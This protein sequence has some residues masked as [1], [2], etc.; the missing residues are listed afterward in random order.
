MSGI[1]RR[2]QSLTPGLTTTCALDD[3]RHAVLVKG[4][5]HSAAHGGRAWI[6]DSSKARGAFSQEI[7][8]FIVN[9]VFPAFQKKGAKYF[10]TVTAES[11]ITK[12]T[13]TRYSQQA[14]PCGLQLVEGQSQNGAI[15]WLMK[16]AA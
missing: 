2:G 9:E 12:M 11:A 10:M 14:G 13:V 16:K 3:F 1:Q 4:L 6:V 7:Q 5:T 8:E 15:E